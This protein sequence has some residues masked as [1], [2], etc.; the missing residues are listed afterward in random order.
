MFEEI[1]TQSRTENGVYLLFLLF[2][3]LAVVTSHWVSGLYGVIIITAITAYFRNRGTLELNLH[4][5]EKILFWF[6]LLNFVVFLISSSLNYPER[7][8]FTRF[9]IEL[10]LVLIIPVYI[11]LLR[12]PKA[13]KYFLI[14]AILSIIVN[15]IAAVSEVYLNE[16]SSFGGVY[17]TLFSGP[18]T[19]LFLGLTIGFLLSK[20][21]FKSKYTLLALGLLSIGIFTI[22]LTQARV[23][24]IAFV[25]VFF[26]ICLFYFTGWT[27]LV[28]VF[29]LTA[30][31]TLVLLFSSSTQQRLDL[32]FKEIQIY[33]A[34]EDRA[35]PEF[36]LGSSSVG[37]RLEMWRATPLFL[38]DTP[39]FGI[40]NGNYHK[41]MSTY[42]EQGKINPT[43]LNHGH[44]HNAFVNALF[45]K[46]LAGLLLVC[47]I[48]F[49]PLYIYIKTY[50]LNPLSSRL[51]IIMISS[52]F[53]F[54]LN[55][56]AP[57]YK[58][59]FVAIYM[60]LTVLLF[61]YHMQHIRNKLSG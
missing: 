11:M 59:N 32:A 56:P 61:S 3:V 40:G 54:S 36:Q 42:V 19:V 44:A 58:G 10:R 7:F 41:V 27:K 60:L 6:L 21:G 18:V 35:N 15:F 49:Y 39:F 9:E 46:G 34:E 20:F 37:T 52:I 30:I 4:R 53:I 51:G 28:S 5:Y 14:G 23:A 43:V 24:Y 16:A 25:L 38:H 48:M 1:K 55:A 47:L 57:F 33:Y 45:N 50:Q 31:I 29:S 12:Y 8:R 26:L 22:I 2:P 17:S 13:L